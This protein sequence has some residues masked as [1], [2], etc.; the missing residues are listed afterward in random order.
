MRLTCDFCGA[1][2][3]TNKDNTCPNCGAA[4]SRDNE[5]ERELKREERDKDLN[6]EK[7]EVDLEAKKIQ[8]EK[9]RMT[10]KNQEIGY[11]SIRTFLGILLAPFAIGLA[12]TIV[13]IVIAVIM[14]IQEVTTGDKIISNNSSFQESSIVQESEKIEEIPVEVKFNEPGSTS[15]Y[16]VTI[17]KA[18]EIDVWPWN[19]N[20]GYIFV[21]FYFIVENITD[22][23]IYS[24]ESITA[25]VN[26][27]KLDRFNYS[28]SK[29][30]KDE[31]IPVGMKIDGWVALSVPLDAKEIVFKYGDY[32]TIKIPFEKIERL[33]E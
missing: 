16:S 4:Y 19:P 17:S 20:E 14:A 30:I 29:H 5:L 31:T 32:I 2:I 24:D 12:I 28:D 33:L 8:N 1:L 11:K 3:D 10:I 22:K 18:K 15:T 13:I 9:Q 21:D 23:D 6:I 26:G 25:S 7:Q 27:I